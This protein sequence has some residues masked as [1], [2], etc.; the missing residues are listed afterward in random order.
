M[1]RKKA[2]EYEKL[3][4]H[5]KNAQTTAQ[6]DGLNRR[7]EIKSEKR[8]EEEQEMINDCRRK[9]ICKHQHFLSYNFSL[10]RKV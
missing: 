3:R 7:Q 6:F 2:M 1:L 9:K 4:E 10:S 5:Y 8:Q